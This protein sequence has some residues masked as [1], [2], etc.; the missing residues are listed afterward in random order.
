MDEKRFH[1][2]ILTP[3]KKVFDGETS[4]VS[5][6][7]VDGEFGV[8]PGHAELV[9]LI[10]PGEVSIEVGE[11]K[12]LMAVSWGYAYVDAT[13]VSLLVENA[14]NAGD[15][16]LDRALK[17][18]DR[19]EKELGGVDAESKEGVKFRSKIERAEARIA[20]ASKLVVQK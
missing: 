11:Q 2:E 8:L 6:P 5:A 9:S 16:D 20:L 15:I 19:W 13:S 3:E 12:T 4:Y 1:L 14:E 18:K 10:R 7:G 17:D